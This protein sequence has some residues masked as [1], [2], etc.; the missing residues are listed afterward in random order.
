MVSLALRWARHSS[1]SW[2]LL[3]ARETLQIYRYPSIFWH[4]TRAALASDVHSV[5]AVQLGKLFGTLAKPP[6]DSYSC[7]EKQN[8]TG[9]VY[10]SK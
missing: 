5:Y 1:G 3:G 10:L 9:D 2:S 4:L 7:G 6:F 8:A